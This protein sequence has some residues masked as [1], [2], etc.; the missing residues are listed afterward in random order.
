MRTLIVEDEVDGREG[1]MNFLR[2]YCPEVE[3]ID[4]AD[5]VEE[6]RRKIRKYSP[7]LLLLDIKL[8]DGN[9]FD[10]LEGLNTQNFE[11]IFI[12]AYPEYAMDAINRSH[13][14]RYLVK[15]IQ[16]TELQEAVAEAAENLKKEK[17]LVALKSR[18]L[19]HHKVLIPNESGFELVYAK[20]ILYC[21]AQGAYTKLYFRKEKLRKL[22]SQ[23]LKHFENCLSDYNFLRVHRSFL[24]NLNYVTGYRKGKSGVVVLEGGI[25]IPVSEEKKRSLLSI[26]KRTA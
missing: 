19:P 9:A 13:C 21:K 2:D 1:L 14:C 17:E 16:I 7:D 25:K 12:T 22:V 3:I 6:A 18:Y 24:I 11:I 15:P 4:T 26:L 23:N 20:D 10:L 5:S 8:L